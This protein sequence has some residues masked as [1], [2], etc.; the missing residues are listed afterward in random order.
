MDA[1]STNEVI[2]RLRGEGLDVTRGYC[3][4]L[5]RERHLEK[6]PSVGRTLI[7]RE[8]NISA[9]REWLESRGR[10]LPDDTTA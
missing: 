2:D 7:W 6:P 5:F 4:F 3:D 10:L 8:E 9:L 1:Y